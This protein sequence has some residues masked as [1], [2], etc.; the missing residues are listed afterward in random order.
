MEDGSFHM[1]ATSRN[2]EKP[3][4]ALFNLRLQLMQKTPAEISFCVR[5][6]RI[7]LMFLAQLALTNCSSLTNPAPELT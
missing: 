2:L 6:L 7:G 4:K 3:E 5:K 1:A